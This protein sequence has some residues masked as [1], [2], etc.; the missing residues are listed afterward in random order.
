MP[1]GGR[2]GLISGLQ[3]HREGERLEGRSRLS[4][5]LGGQVERVLRVVLLAI[6]DRAAHHGPD[7]SGPVVDGHQGGHGSS[8]VV[9]EVLGDDPVGRLLHGEVERR[10]DL[11]TAVVGA[12]LG[13][14]LWGTPGPG[15]R[16]AGSGAEA[17]W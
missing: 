9:G 5:T 17:S 14:V 10:L 6:D 2:V 15:R 7:L 13:N 4:L 16:R 1:K 11:Q 3:R 12:V 8:R